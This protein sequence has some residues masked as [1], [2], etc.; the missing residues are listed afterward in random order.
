M[1]GLAEEVTRLERVI[2]SLE[3]ET[4]CL[5]D[6]LLRHREETRRKSA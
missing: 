1:L 4:E 5:V 2:A 6:E 3:A